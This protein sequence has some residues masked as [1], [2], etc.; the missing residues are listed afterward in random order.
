[1]T[2]EIPLNTFYVKQP[3]TEAVNI[4]PLFK[5]LPLSTEE[6]FEVAEGNK[7][8]CFVLSGSVPN[9]PEYGAA[10]LDGGYLSLYCKDITSLQARQ[11]PK[12]K[13]YILRPHVEILEGGYT[14]AHVSG[15][16]DKPQIGQL[17]NTYYVNPVNPAAYL[18]E[19]FEGAS[20]GFQDS[21]TRTGGGGSVTFS[22]PYIT[23]E[24]YRSALAQ[25]GAVFD[26]KEF[27]QHLVTIG[28]NAYPASSRRWERAP[29]K[30]TG[31]AGMYWTDTG[32]GDWDNSTLDINIQFGVPRKWYIRPGP[33][34]YG[35]TRTSW[36]KAWDGGLGDYKY[37]R[38]SM[39]DYSDYLRYKYQQVSMNNFDNQGE[40]T[41]S[42][43]LFSDFY[44]TRN[45]GNPFQS[46]ISDPLILSSIDFTTE[47]S[48][49]EGQSMRMYN[50]WGYSLENHVIQEG[51]GISG[52]LNPQCV[53]ASIYN[54]P[55]APFPFDLGRATVNSEL[56]DANYQN[57][58]NPNSVLGEIRM[59]INIAK[60]GEM[61][62]L[63]ADRATSVD[64]LHS[65]F[66]DADINPDATLT[67]P[68][69]NHEQTL[70]RSVVVTFSNYKPK[71]EHTTVDKF[72]AY[73]LER[74]YSGKDTENIV[75]GFVFGRPNSEV[76][77]SYGSK[78][79]GEGVN[80]WPLPVGQIGQ[81][82]DGTGTGLVATSGQ[83]GLLSGGIH[84]IN[85]QTGSGAPYDYNLEH[86]DALTWGVTANATGT[87]DDDQVLRTVSMPM[88]TWTT[89]RIFIDPDQP[90]NFGSTTKRPYAVSGAQNPTMSSYKD[91]GVP[92]R[93]LFETQSETTQMVTMSGSTVISASGA[94]VDA[95][96]TNLPFIDVFF[97]IGN[98]KVS[99]GV[100]G[101]NYPKGGANYTFRDKPE[102]YPQHMT[103]WVQNFPWITGYNGDGTA[104]Q[105]YRTF[106]WG[107][108]TQYPEGSVMETE[109]FIDSLKL[110]NFTPSI[111]N[112]SVGHS[113]GGR[114]TF[115]PIDHYSPL[116]VQISGTSAQDYKNA[117]VGSHPINITG[118]VNLTNTSADVTI[119]ADNIVDV[120]MLDNFGTVTITDTTGSD[121]YIPAG[122]TISS[123]NNN[124]AFTMSAAATSTQTATSV[125]FTSTGTTRPPINRANLTNYNTGQ[126]LVFGLDGKDYL[127][128]D[129]SATY[130]AGYILCNN[131]LTENFE[132]AKSN[133]L[134][135]RKTDHYNGL[136]AGGAL[137]SWPNA[138]PYSITNDV[139]TKLGSQLYGGGNYNVGTLASPD[140]TTASP[141]GN[142]SG[143]IFQV[144]DAAA[145]TLNSISTTT[146]TTNEFASND[147][148]R[149][150]GFMYVSVSGAD[151]NNGIGF[152]NWSK[153]EMILCS[154]KVTNV[155]SVINNDS[156]D[157]NNISNN[158]LK[159]HTLQPFD[160]LN[161]DETYIVYEMGAEEITSGYGSGFKSG[162]KLD[163]TNTPNALERLLSFTE[164]LKYADDGKTE[165]FIESKLP[166]LWICPEKYWF[167][168]LFDSPTTTINRNYSSFCLIGETPETTGSSGLTALSGSTFNEYIYSYNVAAAATGGAAGVYYRMW[169]LNV[170]SQEQDTVV[171]D[172]DYGFG[173][174]SSDNLLAGNAIQGD[175]EFEKYNYY[176]VS[177]VVTVG[178]VKPTDS[179]P[180]ML[181]HGGDGSKNRSMQFYADDY[182]TDLT[183]RPLFYWRFRDEPPLLNN[184]SVGPAVNVVGEDVDLYSLTSDSLNSVKFTWDEENAD[185]VWY[186]MLMVDSNTN[187]LDKYH[188]CITHMPF[189]ESITDLSATPS[190]TA[191]NPVSGT[192]VALTVDSSVKSVIEGQG[193]Y[194]AYV[195]GG[196]A[197][198]I[199][200]TSTADWRGLQ[201]LDD[202]TLVVHWTPALNSRGLNQYI[203]GQTDDFTSSI[204]NFVMYKHTNDKIIVHF[205]GVTLNG[206]TAITCDGKTPVCLIV[207]NN[208]G[209]K[210]IPRQALYVNGVRED[211]ASLLTVEITGDNDFVIAPD[212]L[213]GAANGAQGMIEEVLLYS[214][215]WDVVNNTGEY[216]YSSANLT[217]F[218]GSS[219]LNDANYSQSAR[220]F[221]MD[222]HNFRG[223][224]KKHLGMS[225]QVGWRTVTV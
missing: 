193:G 109:V 93:V 125:V 61:I 37:H 133:S 7:E 139:Y 119:V 30:G 170:A 48:L 162:L 136:S 24:D 130:G 46:N 52:N 214:E 66:Y 158:Q 209:S 215:E 63:N 76:Q 82:N 34:S 90:N 199:T 148:W 137:L 168:M 80:V 62:H 221:A 121:S 108:D 207:T 11:N 105:L 58:I 51:V 189:N 79:R 135:P 97:P 167:T 99:R 21:V 41:Q 166:N 118:N 222:Y 129:T 124:D 13:G 22:G 55:M 112:L 50:N 103:I 160:F 40:V 142:I 165:L 127:P 9:Y 15:N 110:F 16:T 111:N 150:K 206:T 49:N 87:Y 195:S 116:Q 217:E 163:N 85:G 205:D 81:A 44:A 56:T 18:S 17:L 164:T 220:L 172:V 149:Q 175:V 134:L 188:K 173:V 218:S 213:G 32:A 191:Y 10:E 203:I 131:Y 190:F 180:F 183:R 33:E 69:T 155:A 83:R 86:C 74:F 194:A 113:A 145:E 57:H 92:M 64:T 29:D 210:N 45:V 184:F 72:I 36:A 94:L 147:G 88:N 1:M 91:T 23:K 153:R 186:R 78:Y 151:A 84:K 223:S 161:E 53:R 156:F 107:D 123:F 152:N 171:N 14:L 177:N 143:A 35:F 211:A 27:E 75:G 115:K 67:T 224:S 117:W 114:A 187:I 204:D 146:G 154:S 144:Q 77:A 181:V 225:S 132:E 98:S 3:V 65:Y 19:E 4:S 178:G 122:T 106:Y 70:L 71:V 26:E 157:N 6:T 68:Y 28:Y 138:G 20:S 31:F 212:Y 47:K 176:D 12:L 5:D 192:S 102:W 54:L 140:A 128:L 2:I 73:G 182:T 202:W 197:D 196:A 174:F 38:F 59:P 89:C 219:S 126:F 42:N 8:N 120:T 185:D 216:I 200:L 39:D 141:G 104:P 100:E 101:T 159:V 25:A 96:V 208:N 95:A 169:D 198:Q 179:V 60:L 201:G 43:T